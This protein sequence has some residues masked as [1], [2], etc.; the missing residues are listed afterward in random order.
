MVRER[1]FD[2]SEIRVSQE[3]ILDKKISRKG[4]EVGN[5]V[6]VFTGQHD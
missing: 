3:D 5:V 4:P 2:L 1:V 6:G